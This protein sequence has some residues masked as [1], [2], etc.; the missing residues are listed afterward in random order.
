MYPIHICL[1]LQSC[2]I[3]CACQ[4]APCVVLPSTLGQRHLIGVLSYN[5][6]SA[7]CIHSREEK[8]TLGLIHSHAHGQLVC[9]LDLNTCI[10]IILGALSCRGHL[11]VESLFAGTG[12]SRVVGCCS[13]K[14][15]LENAS[16]VS[17]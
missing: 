14:E 12:S 3:W 15:R 6:S 11:S 10:N 1:S 2:R 9:F 8:S 13:S 5:G 4:H 7:R 17:G 16:N